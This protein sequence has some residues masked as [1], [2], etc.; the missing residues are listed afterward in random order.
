MANRIEK[1]GCIGKRFFTIS[2]W[3]DWKWH[4]RNRIRSVKGLADLLGVPVASLSTWEAVLKV[5]PVVISPYYLSLFD[6]TDESD[7]LRRQCFPDPK[8]INFSIGGVEDP[9]EEERHM[10]V[11][12]LI[13]R[14]SDRCLAIVTGTCAV[15]CRHCN[16]KRLWIKDV[17]S[18]KERLRS[19]V[20]YVAH[21]PELREVIISGGDPLLISEETLDWFLGSLR[22]I[23]HVEVLRIGS[24]VPVT[25]PM[26]I[27]KELCEMMRK[28]RPLWLNTQ[29]NHP[30]E[31]TEDSAKACEM[32]LEAGIPVSNQSVLL[33]G[34]NDDFK[35][36]KE[37]LYGLERI[38][39]RPYY[40]FQ[41]DPV[42]G[43]DHFRTDIWV[44]MEIMEKLWRNV[45]GLCLPRF[46]LDC[47]GGRGKIPFQP[48]SFLPESN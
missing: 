12:G 48:F 46:V 26:R 47:P 22:A 24:R 17:K 39:V 41:C 25:L 31:I 30:R 28:H 14:Y 11:P 27:T 13:Q 20:D 23:K 2:E 32:L 44:G 42:R 19:M 36:M 37:L 4:F 7:P 34:I 5:Y 40:L 21:T 16:R 38:S 35:I 10:P 43:A 45:S 3:N 8:E 33:K 1:I 18:S 9:L 6:Y 29:F 15:Y